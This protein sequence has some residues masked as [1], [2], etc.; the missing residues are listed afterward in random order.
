VVKELYS[1]LRFHLGPARRRTT[2]MVLIILVLGFLLRLYFALT[3]HLNLDEGSYLY[4]AQLLRDG[5]VPFRDY[6][7]RSPL[8][9]VLL[10]GSISVF[11]ESYLAGRLLSVLLSTLTIPLIYLAAHRIFDRGTG[12]VAAFLFAFSPFTVYCGALIFTETAQVFFLTMAF[13]LLLRGLDRTGLFP[14]Y[15]L[16]SGVG[17]GEAGNNGKNGE[18]REKTKEGTTL[19]YPREAAVSFFLAGVVLAASV[20]IRRTSLLVFVSVVLFLLGLLINEK[21]KGT[22]SPPPPTNGFFSYVLL[23][24]VL[25]FFLT[26]GVSLALLFHLVG[27]EHYLESFFTRAG[28]IS[29]GSNHFFAFIHFNERGFYL[30]LTFLFAVIYGAAALLMKQI[31]PKNE[32]GGSEPGTEREEQPRHPSFG[33]PWYGPCSITLLVL[34]YLLVAML[35]FLFTWGLFHDRY[36]NHGITNLATSLIYLFAIIL[37]LAIV[38]AVHPARFASRFLEGVSR[39]HYLLLWFW[40][41]GVFLF[42]MGY[43]HIY[44]VYIYEFIV[45][46]M[47]L[48]AHVLVG[49]YT[50]FLRDKAF[51]FPGSSI[52]KGSSPS[53]G[54]RKTDHEKDPH[55]VLLT[56]FGRS[57]GRTARPGVPL[58]VLLFLLL[59][60]LSSLNGYGYYLRDNQDQEF[61][62]PGDVSDAAVYIKDHTAPGEEIFAA[63]CMVAFEADRPIIFHLSHPTVYRPTHFPNRTKD[64]LSLEEMNYPEVDEI[65]SYLKENQVRYIVVDPHMEMNFLEHHASLRE[66]IEAYYTVEKEFGKIQILALKTRK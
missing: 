22:T 40:F 64:F 4:D 8:L 44:Q 46:A 29:S 16:L 13:V 49:F 7:T 63:N 57:L 27:P 2:A 23:P 14:G 56:S 33:T 6:Y 18:D 62:T 37:F 5:K 3:V 11:G 28:T 36:A 21:R 26:G 50:I 12:F 55:H 31:P 47:I 35:F 45:P 54:D 39:Y 30:Y 43:D 48:V 17:E 53:S 42:Y 51:A 66:H 25:G 9:L 15:S 58:L 38:L 61:A 1:F 60:L 41:F 34:S 10:A 19:F 20:H 52:G 59:M 65:I 32:G 24:F